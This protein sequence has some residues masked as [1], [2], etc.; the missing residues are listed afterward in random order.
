MAERIKGISTHV[1]D[2]ARGLP[3]AGIS[4]RL[5]IQIG[6]EWIPVHS[7]STDADGRCPDLLQGTPLAAAV[8]RITYE[9]GSYFQSSSTVFLFP[10]VIITF[11]VRDPQIHYHIPLLLGPNTYTTYRGS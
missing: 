8:Y 5:D 9:T 11:V 3:A 10:E 1:L 7:S 2:T 6:T 4:V